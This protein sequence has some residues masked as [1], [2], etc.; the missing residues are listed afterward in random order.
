MF[1]VTQ[2]SPGDKI[3]VPSNSGF[4]RAV[5][6]HHTF[7]ANNVAYAVTEWRN[8]FGQSFFEVFDHNQIRGT[9]D[10]ENSNR[11]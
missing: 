7:T 4:D 3:F 11:R 9:V 8:H 6:V 2:L 10:A 1:D 5:T